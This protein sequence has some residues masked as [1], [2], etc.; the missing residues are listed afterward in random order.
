MSY[1]FARRL[2]LPA[3][4]CTLT[5]PAW[6]ANGETK[7]ISTPVL[8]PAQPRSAVTTQPTAPLVS[9]SARDRALQARPTTVPTQTLGNTRSTQAASTSESARSATAIPATGNPALTQRVRELESNLLICRGGSGI[10]PQPTNQWDDG[11]SSTMLVFSPALDGAGADGSWLK[12][13][14]CGFAT[15][16]WVMSDPPAV[17]VT[18][19]RE[20]VAANGRLGGIENHLRNPNYY[21]S[22]VVENSN[23]GYFQALHNAKFLGDK[24]QVS[25]GTA[26][27]RAKCSARQ[28][29]IVSRGTS[30]EQRMER[31][32]CEH[33]MLDAARAAT[34]DQKIADVVAWLDAQP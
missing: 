22:F 8:Q 28:S 2:L 6:P 7:A 3:L 25:A 5:A 27:Q 13:G 19:T 21:W 18:L 12:E 4:L 20:E 23:R 15:R 9:S 26:Q 24:T 14:S 29:N 10:N 11:T 30:L 17:T 33:R 1:L 16:K 32:R 34:L 31:I